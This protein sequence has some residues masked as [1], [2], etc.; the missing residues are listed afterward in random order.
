MTASS[1]SWQPTLCTTNTPGAESE[2]G[3]FGREAPPFSGKARPGG[4]TAYY[5]SSIPFLAAATA[6]ATS[7]WTP[8]LPS[9]ARSSGARQLRVAYVSG[10]A[11][12]PH[13][14]D[15][16]ARLARATIPSLKLLACTHSYPGLPTH[17]FRVNEGLPCAGERG[18]GAGAG[19]S[20]GIWLALC[21]QYAVNWCHMAPHG[22]V[23]SLVATK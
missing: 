5:A 18:W 14:K 22:G 11:W 1:H 8:N 2:R 17:L 6:P 12:N 3:G 19:G 9:K 16:P 21:S 20:E 4:C 23:C 7:V 15:S 13:H 10:P